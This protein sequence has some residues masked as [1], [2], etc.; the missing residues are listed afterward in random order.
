MTSEEVKKHRREHRIRVS[1]H[2][3][4]SKRAARGTMFVNMRGYGGSQFRDPIAAGDFAMRQLRRA[5]DFHAQ[6]GSVKTLML[7]GIPV[8]T[9]LQLMPRSEIARRLRE[10]GALRAS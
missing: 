8:P 9:E 5:E 1:G 2:E 3:D 10:S 4:Q 7:Y 6:H